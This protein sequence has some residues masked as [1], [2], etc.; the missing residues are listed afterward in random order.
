[1]KDFFLAP[2]LP[3][4]LGEGRAFFE[5]PLDGERELIA[6]LDGERKGA[7]EAARLCVAALGE[8]EFGP[9]IVGEGIALAGLTLQFL[10]PWAVVIFA[11][12]CACQMQRM[13]NE[14]R[15][16]LRAFPEYRNY[17]DRTARLVPHLY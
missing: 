14:E 3:I 5:D 7:G 13:K 6:P 1:M 12:Q 11:L 9:D 2:I 15:V 16:L 17:M 8:Q 4:D 10:S